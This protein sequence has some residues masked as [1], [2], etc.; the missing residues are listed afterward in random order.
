MRAIAVRASHLAGRTAV[1]FAVVVFAFLVIGPH[2]GRYRTLTV[3]TA[4]MRPTFPPGSVV[5]V[6]PT[7]TAQVAVGDVITYAIPVEDHHL[8]THRVIEVVRPGV[9]R[10][11]GDANDVD[12]PWVAQLRGPTAWRV[13]AGVPGLG[14]AIEALRGPAA[15]LVLVGVTTLAGLLVG[16][17]AIWRR[18]TLA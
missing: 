2:S 13:R 9:V 10:T 18:P 15:H 4:S 11:R 14:Y 5:I 17:G 6:E 12:D 16:L 7:P 8:V 3:L 1:A